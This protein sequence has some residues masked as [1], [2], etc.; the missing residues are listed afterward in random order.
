M[1]GVEYGM[2]GERWRMNH[3]CFGGR[4]L[5]AA[6]LDCCSDCIYSLRERNSERFKEK[7]SI[8]SFKAWRNIFEAKKL[9]QTKEAWLIGIIV[10]GETL[11]QSTKI[12]EGLKPRKAASPVLILTCP[13]LRCPVFVL[14]CP[15]KQWPNPQTTSLARA[16]RARSFWLA[17]LMRNIILQKNVLNCQSLPQCTMWK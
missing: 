15:V 3:Q 4:S 9:S 14:F 5:K 16:S 1:N 10:S 11:V 6:E 7:G 13:T 17:Q 8:T 12:S 2:K